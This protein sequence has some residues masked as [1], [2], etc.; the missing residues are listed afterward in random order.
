MTVCYATVIRLNWSSMGFGGGF[1]F[2]D[3]ILIKI[4]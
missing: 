3:N 2:T 1:E 4:L